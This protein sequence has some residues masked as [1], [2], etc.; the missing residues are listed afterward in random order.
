MGLFVQT[1]VSARMNGGWQSLTAPA[2]P[3]GPDFTGQDAA[4]A[5]RASEAESYFRSYSGRSLSA[6]DTPAYT[7]VPPYIQMPAGAQ[8]YFT[9]KSIATPVQGSGD[10]T[11]LQF[12][13]PVG[14]D[15]VIEQIANFYTGGG[16]LI[17]SGDFVW[18]LLR[19]GQAIRG[20]D[21]IPCALGQ[22]NQGGVVP[23]P[24]YQSPIRIF[25][26]EQISYVVNHAAGSLLP[27]AGTWCFALVAG[28][29]YQ[30]GGTT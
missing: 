2:A 11:I 24:L 6:P 12:T 20:F 7:P 18:R 8:P 1:D 27:D 29:F 30:K 21:A 4:L 26:G 5:A 22:Y 25:E 19:N 17:G 28:Y 14:W 9:P 10:T 15:G 3:L 13:V 23:V 16:F